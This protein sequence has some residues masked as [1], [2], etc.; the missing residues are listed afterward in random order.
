MFTLWIRN[1][2]SMGLKSLLTVCF[3]TAIVTTSARANPYGADMLAAIDQSDVRILSY[4]AI[5]TDTTKRKNTTPEQ[6]LEHIKTLNNEAN[7]IGL[8]RAIEAWENGT[9]LPPKA[10]VITFDGSDRSIFTRAYPILKEYNMPFTAL[11]VPTYADKG[12][13]QYLSWNDIEAMEESGLA[14]IG[15]DPGFHGHYSS[16]KRLEAAFFEEKAKF[17]DIMGYSALYINGFNGKYDKNAL[18]FIQNQEFKAILSYIEGV[19]YNFKQKSDENSENNTSQVPLPR[20]TM[21]ESFADE[22]RLKM[23]LNASALPA[24][25]ITPLTTLDTTRPAPTLGFSAARGNKDITCKSMPADMINV[26]T[27]GDERVEIRIKLPDDN[28]A[29]RKNIKTGQVRIQCHQPLNENMGV[30]DN[31]GYARRM[32]GFLW[33]Q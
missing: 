29:N 31:Q 19:S 27:I 3:V 9:P 15:L 13:P 12:A 32:L 14:T 30:I 33:Y 26:E 22:T 24:Y 5:T 11:I 17:R 21:T 7:V 1:L 25:D 20:F 4:F 23:I 2:G 6:F 18:E 28:T 10:V 8:P 16:F